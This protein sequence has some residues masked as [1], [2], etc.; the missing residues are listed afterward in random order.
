MGG[1]ELG[2]VA[3]QRLGVE[4]RRV[5][6]AL[7]V[8]VAVLTSSI[9]AAFAQDPSARVEAALARIEAR[10]TMLS[11]QLLV[12]LDQAR[13][14]RQPIATHCIDD[15]LTEVHALIRIIQRDQERLAAALRMH[16]DCEVHRIENTLR[17]QR[18]RVWELT[19]EGRRC[20][21]A[22]GLAGNEQTQIEV[23]IDPDTPNIDPTHLP[24]E[25]PRGA[26]RPLGY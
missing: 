15:K 18:R 16:D 2:R 12:R 22:N 25:R 21:D 4:Q 26:P 5:L 19:R 1:I 20:D 24:A 9:P 14:E 10:A 8:C 23:T 13:S 11:R 17:V 7:V 3:R 6:R